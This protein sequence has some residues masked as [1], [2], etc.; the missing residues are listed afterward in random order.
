M[1]NRKFLVIS[2][3]MMKF[4][5][6]IALFSR[7]LIIVPRKIGNPEEILL[8]EN[9]ISVHSISYFTRKYNQ[10]PRKQGNLTTKFHHNT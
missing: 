2:C 7:K 8:R 10:F 4:G 1:N 9:S 5:G 6:Q 3:I